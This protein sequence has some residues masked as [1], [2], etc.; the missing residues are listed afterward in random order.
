VSRSR[1]PPHL[2]AS[3][4]FS[5]TLTIISVTTNAQG[6]ADAGQFTADGTV[7]EYQV[8]ASTA[9]GESATY[10]LTNAPL[11]IVKAESGGEQI[12]NINAVFGS[13]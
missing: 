6:I 10:S 8:I 5:D 7:G 4:T 3:G 13:T 9:D 1:S 11:P 2:R 12:V